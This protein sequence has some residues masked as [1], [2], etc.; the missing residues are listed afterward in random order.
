MEGVEA[1]V[2][3]KDT[4]EAVAVVEGAEVMVRLNSQ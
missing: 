2:A 1:A 3:A 4:A